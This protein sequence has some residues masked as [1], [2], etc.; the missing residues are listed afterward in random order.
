M[1]HRPLADVPISPAIAALPKADLH[2]H[3]EEVARF[4][5][6]VAQRLGRPPH[7]WRES[8]RRLL[9][10]TPPGRNRLLGMYAPDQHLDLAGEPHDCPENVIA[11][12]AD[13][14]EAG[15]ADGALLLELRFGASGW[16]LNRPDFMTLFRDAERKV[17]VRYP[18]FLSL[19]HI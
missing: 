2:I 19:I 18:H 4:E 6:V 10:E 14:M 7:D 9:S 16:M 12:M 13:A 11:I 1:P 8:A 15:A 5:R 3:Q 17:G